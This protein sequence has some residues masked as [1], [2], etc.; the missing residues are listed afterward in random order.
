MAS[1]DVDR[2]EPTDEQLARLVLRVLA[3]LVALVLAAGVAAAAERVGEDG[4]G[5]D[6]AAEDVVVGGGSGPSSLSPR[7]AIG[8][9]PG[10][11][12]PR[13]VRSRVEPLQSL[14]DG[15]RRA[16]VVSFSGYRSAD[17]ARELVRG[18][19]VASL[20]VALP[21]GRPSEVAPSEDLAAL[22]ARQRA[23]ATAEKK[24]LEQLLPTVKDDDFKRQYEADIERLTALL[25][26]PATGR[27]LVFGAVVV[28]SGERLRIIAHR[29]GVRLV[30]VGAGATAPKAGEA[31]GLRPEETA[32]AGEPAVRRP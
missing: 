15:T 29:P 1:A 26:A 12:V 31:A 10:T 20:L 30:D 6:E 16:A 23:D 9:L 18:A 4:G 14:P 8:P 22:V 11:A 21:G 2:V 32:T 13:Y 3:A 27:D 19:Q 28:G 5:R 24:A 17:A 7:G 25:A